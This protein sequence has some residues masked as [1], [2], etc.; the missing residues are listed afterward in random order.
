MPLGALLNRQPLPPSP[1][2]LPLLLAASEAIIAAPKT[3]FFFVASGAMVPAKLKEDGP[4][5]K[6]ASRVSSFS[7][8]LGPKSKI[9]HETHENISQL[10]DMYVYIYIYTRDI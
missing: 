3:A 10:H 2:Q 9:C 5:E 8:R 1:P 4:R 7:T 6:P